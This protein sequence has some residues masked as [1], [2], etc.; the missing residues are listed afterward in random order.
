MADFQDPKEVVK[1]RL[2]TLKTVNQILTN[3]AKEK[4][5]KRKPIRLPTTKP[6]ISKTIVGK[7]KKK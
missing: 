4:K 5:K 1:S 2:K 3:V 7:G 6:V